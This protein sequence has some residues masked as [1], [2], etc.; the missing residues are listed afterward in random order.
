MLQMTPREAAQ[1][2]LDATT[3]MYHG[4]AP[5]MRRIILADEAVRL[6][7][8]YPD[9]EQDIVCAKTGSRYFYHVHPPGERAGDEH[10]HFHLF[11]PR[12]SMADPSAAKLAPPGREHS[13]ADV[14]HIVALSVNPTGL[15]IA[16]FTVNRWVT[17]EWLFPAPAIISAL[18]RFAL[19]QTRGDALVDRWL[20]AAVY[21]C[22]PLIVDVLLARDNA[23]AAADWAG[24][25]RALEVL[26][27]VDL[28]LSA[29][30]DKLLG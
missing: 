13:D 14:V 25:D 21:L 10:G 7:D 29:L 19:Q 6:W 27:T 9:P 2:L 4:G 1:E 11:L 26:S 28:D 12:T 20:T 5:L 24:E 16:L 23:L 18:D 8:H 30:L 22:R 15:P 3:A 17:D